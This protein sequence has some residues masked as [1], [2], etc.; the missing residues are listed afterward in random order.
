MGYSLMVQGTASDSGKSILVAGLC[1]VFHQEGLKVLPF[2]SQNMALNSYITRKGDEM[3]RAQ[4]FQAE[5]A[6]IEPDVSM[7]P[8]LLKPTSDRKSQVVFMGKVLRDMDAVEYHEFKPQLIDQI[9][10]LYQQLQQENDVIVIEGAGSPAEINLN[11]RDIANMGMARIADAPVILVADIDK[12]GVFA[13]IYGTIMLLEP[14]D[15]QRV[16]G[17]VINKFRG[18]IALLE[19]GLAMIEELTGVPVIGVIPYAQLN[20]ED[21]DSVALN[22]VNRFYDTHKALDVAVLGLSKI[23]NFTD[24]NSL[25]LEPDVSLRYVFPGDQVGDPDLL[26]I[27]GSKNTLED[28]VYL[29]ESGFA[30]EVQ[31]LRVGNKQIFGIC[32]GYQL[33][34]KMLHDPQQVESS[35]GS[36]PGLGLLDVETYFQQEKTTTQVTAVTEGQT[37][38]GYEIHMGRTENHEARDFAEIHTANGEAVQRSDGAISADRRVMGTYLHGIFDNSQW[39]RDLLNQI[40]E[41]KGLA[42]IQEVQIPYQEYKAQQ[43]D[44]LAELIRENLDM[45][46]VYEIMG[47]KQ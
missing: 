4:V 46:K 33:L 16:K 30:A 32:G 27:P 45:E 26:I 42:P 29:Q 11:S 21:E 6:G 36:L 12:G 18:D 38:S 10:Q 35:H 15:R 7:N 28:A 44:K 40:R 22:Q 24:F 43:Y 13:S 17:I 34:G 41:Q 47:A 5:A 1:R 3:G 20:I 25:A 2:K 8:V 14:A 37:V 23:A 19:P 31:R 39:R 9:S